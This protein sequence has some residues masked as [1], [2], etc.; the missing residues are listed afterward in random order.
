MYLSI[1][2]ARQLSPYETRDLVNALLEM[3]TDV[4]SDEDLEEVLFDLGIEEQVMMLI[5]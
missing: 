3:Q 4:M 2:D 5:K 1:E